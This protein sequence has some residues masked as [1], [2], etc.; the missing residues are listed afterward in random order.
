VG[1]RLFRREVGNTHHRSIIKKWA[2]DWWMV[3]PTIQ[4]KVSIR[5]EIISMVNQ[6]STVLFVGAFDD[7][8]YRIHSYISAC[9]S[10]GI[11]CEFISATEFVGGGADHS[12]SHHL[13]FNDE[14]AIRTAA[15]ACSSGS[16]IAAEHS[17]KVAALTPFTDKHLVRL[18][19]GSAFPHRF[20]K[21]TDDN[22]GLNFVNDLLEESAAV[23]VKPA[24]GSCAVGVR[25][26][27]SSKQVM[28]YAAS[29]GSDT[30]IIVEEYIEGKHF[31]IDVNWDGQNVHLSGFCW[32]V[33]SFDKSPFIIGHSA[34]DAIQAGL[35]DLV[36][37]KMGEI[38]KAHCAGIASNFHCEFV[39]SATDGLPYLIEIN[40]RAPGGW[41]PELYSIATGASY[42]INLVRNVVGQAPVPGS[43]HTPA[44]L[45]S[46]SNP[47]FFE[48]P[49]REDVAS[50][51]IYERFTSEYMS[52]I[53]KVG[54]FLFWGTSSDQ[55]SEDFETTLAASMPHEEPDDDDVVVALSA[56]KCC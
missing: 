30:S 5:I 39:L 35:V 23:V 13:V 51:S 44:A 41:L 50:S 28:D 31:C 25:K 32:K 42:D 19:S 34:I 56:S 6:S 12:R 33:M 18:V 47:E 7:H 40:P 55:V 21:L 11:K 26:C 4:F 17:A 52:G 9:A 2:I 24:V 15:D 29:L 54:R 45:G 38:L 37:K 14:S 49:K 53:A 43:G 8:F 22:A 10:L 27:V 48:N 20:T 1:H 46:I 16:S 3:T 36:V